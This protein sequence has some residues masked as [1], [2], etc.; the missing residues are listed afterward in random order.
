MSTAADA[1]RRYQYMLR[2]PDP[3]QIEQAHQQAFAAMTPS[4]RDEVLQ[5]LAKTSEVPSDASPTSLARSA[6]WL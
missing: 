4:E 1:A 2:T 3:T 5:A 6:T